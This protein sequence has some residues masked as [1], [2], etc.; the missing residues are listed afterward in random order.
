[1]YLSPF[2]TVKVDRQPAF[3]CVTKKL[4]K[5]RLKQLQNFF[6]FLLIYIHKV[7]TPGFRE[8]YDGSSVVQDCIPDGFLY[9]R[10]R[11]LYLEIQAMVYSHCKSFLVYE[12]TDG[13][14][15]VNLV[16]CSYLSSELVFIEIY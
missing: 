14:I 5:R 11:W 8:I 7:I 6:N 3:F 13:H 4:E 16:F 1:M 2:D 10:K 12:K 15:H 9:V